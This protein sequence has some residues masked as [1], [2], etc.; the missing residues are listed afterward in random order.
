MKE[1]LVGFLFFGVLLA[2]AALN[3]A[4]AASDKTLRAVVH[5]DLKILDPTWTTTY[6]TN[7]YGYLVY[8][9]LFALNSKFETKPQMV[10]TYSISDDKLTYTFTLRKGMTFHDGQPVR[11]ADCVASLKHWVVRDMMG[12][13]LAKVTADYEVVDD[14]T[15]R[16]KLTEP[17]GLVIDTLGKPATPAFI[18][19][20]RIASKP[21]TE[22]ITESIGSGPFMMKRDE[23]RPGNKAVFVKF[24]NYIPRSEPPDYM[25]GGKISHEQD[26]EDYEA[27][28][29][30]DAQGRVDEEEADR[31]HGD[32]CQ[33][34]GG[35]CSEHALDDLARPLTGPLD[36]GHASVEEAE[37]QDRHAQT[38]CDPDRSE[39]RSDQQ[40]DHDGDAAG[41][42]RHEDRPTQQP[43]E[44]G[45]LKVLD[46]LEHQR[47]L[48]LTRT[49]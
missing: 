36:L 5:A 31:D 7:R 28:D 29:H 2:F 21:A 20:E 44:N 43:L 3:G 10:D 45:G 27:H 8:D 37:V 38:E 18:M 22:Q 4:Q 40:R 24:A 11:A 23:W 33:P 34:G 6:I 13:M 14:L 1:R 19:P 15:F 42:Q 30:A 9:T 39:G 35:L 49:F 16:L 12:Q 47:A 17:Y 32:D 46:V 41:D 26:L 25:S 48:P